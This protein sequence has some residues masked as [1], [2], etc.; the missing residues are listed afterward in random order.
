LGEG[1]L[2]T[3]VLKSRQMTLEV[4]FALHEECT[5]LM[6]FSTV[7]GVMFVDFGFSRVVIIAVMSRG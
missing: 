3:V 1:D 2:V 6:G 7:E 5:K 4:E